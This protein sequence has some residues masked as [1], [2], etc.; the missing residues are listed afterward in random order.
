M[1]KPQIIKEPYNPKKGEYK[2]QN[3]RAL[4]Q[5]DQRTT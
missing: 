2:E 4:I 1:M 5:E 3:G